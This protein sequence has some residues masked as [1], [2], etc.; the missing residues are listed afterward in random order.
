MPPGTQMTDWN[1][2]SENNTQDEVEAEEGADDHEDSLE[3]SSVN[4]D[5]ASASFTKNEN[6]NITTDTNNTSIDIISNNNNNSNN[7]KSNNN[8]DSEYIQNGIM[9]VNGHDG[10]ETLLT[11]EEKENGEAKSDMSG[12]SVNQLKIWK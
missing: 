11:S 10:N 8:N 1:A 6:N 4:E 5:N 12:E 9:E 2:V 7:N 3:E